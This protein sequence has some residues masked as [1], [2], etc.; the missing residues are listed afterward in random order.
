MRVNQDQLIAAFSKYFENEILDKA[1]N[2][3]EKFKMGFV[4]GGLKNRLPKIIVDLKNNPLISAMNIFDDDNFIDVDEVIKY[5]KE[6]IRKTG[7]ITIANIM[8][9][10]DD[11]DSIYRYLREV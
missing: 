2:G 3:L 4:Y 1:P 10:E 9:S 8:F 5:A 11:L 7:K 6:S